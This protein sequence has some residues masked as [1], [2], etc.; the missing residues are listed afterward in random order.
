MQVF[1]ITSICF[2]NLILWFVFF[3]KFKNLFSIDNEIQKARE[4]FQ[5]LMNDIN[6]NTLENINLI[7]MKI[8]E[9]NSLIETA[10]RRLNAIHSDKVF[11]IANNDIKNNIQKLNKNS[12]IVNQ[13]V[14]EYIK[15]QKL[16]DKK[17]IKKPKVANDEILKEDSSY[18]LVNK[19]TRKKRQSELFDESQN[20]KLNQVHYVDSDGNGYGEVPIVS[21][22]IYMSDNPIEIKKSYKEKVLHLHNFGFSVE[23]IAKEL[24]KSITEVQF[25][26]DMYS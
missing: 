15:N 12:N 16:S 20:E 3:I 26:I 19:K 4:Q 10:D 8:D 14:S 18:E 24:N 21:P 6:K 13:N 11:S 25:V 17:N 2:I 7:D 22:K 5:F 1:I 23:K 9:L